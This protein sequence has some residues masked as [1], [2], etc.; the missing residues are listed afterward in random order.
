DSIKNQY[1]IFGEINYSITKLKQD[2]T[3]VQNAT[4]KFLT[5]DQVTENLAIIAQQELENPPEVSSYTLNF[6]S[7]LH[8][9][10]KIL[11]TIV[12]GSKKIEELVNNSNLNTWVQAGHELHT[13]RTT[14]AFCSN[15]ISEIRR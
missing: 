7:L 1:S 8:S 3:S 6:S 14:C 12:G 13:D 10:T 5:D 9:T 15:E 11:K 2:I 4:Y